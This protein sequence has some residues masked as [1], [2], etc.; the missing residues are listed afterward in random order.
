MRRATTAL[1]KPARNPAGNGLGGKARSHRTAIWSMIAA[2][3]YAKM[4]RSIACWPFRK[5]CLGEL[6][7]ARAQV[8]F[9]N[10]CL[11]QK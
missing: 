5:L 4:K 6:V 11:Y 3:T 7:A 10:F 9:S 1:P 8:N 2:V